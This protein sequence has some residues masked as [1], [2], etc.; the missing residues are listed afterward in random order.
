EEPARPRAERARAIRL[1]AG[2]AARFA[3][4]TGAQ[5]ARA[6]VGEAPVQDLAGNRAMSVAGALLRAT[7]S[8]LHPR[9]LWL[10]LWPVLLALL[11][12]GTVAFFLL[13]WLVARLAERL[14]QGV[15]GALPFLA[16]D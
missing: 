13:G 15:H 12:W 5:D 14:Q 3:L 9:M 10:M 7:G 2:R 1:A 16:F 11:L 8:L 4:R 6:G